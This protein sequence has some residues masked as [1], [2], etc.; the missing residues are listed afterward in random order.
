MK[1]KKLEVVAIRDIIREERGDPKA[2]PHLPSSNRKITAI[3]VINKHILKTT[4]VGRVIGLKKPGKVVRP[5]GCCTQV[6]L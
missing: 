4:Y 3:L 5:A 6:G 2:A 1:T